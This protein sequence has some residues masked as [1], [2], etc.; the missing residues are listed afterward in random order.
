MILNI[1][2]LRVLVLG[3]VNH[4]FDTPKDREF[5]RCQILPKMVQDIVEVWC[6]GFKCTENPVSFVYTIAYERVEYRVIM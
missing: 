4:I 2:R 5:E 3:T 1:P 6:L